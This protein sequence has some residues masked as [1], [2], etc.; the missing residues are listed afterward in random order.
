MKDGRTTL[1]LG[2]AL[3]ICVVLLTQAG[4]HAGAR[5]GGGLMGT[6][7]PLAPSTTSPLLGAYY[8]DW[9]PGNSSEGTLRQHLVPS[10][11]SDP[12]LVNSAEPSVASRAIAQASKAGISFFALDY[13][14]SRPAQN[15]NIRAFVRA[16]DLR[17]VHF[18]LLYETWDLG[19]DAAHEATPVTL[20]LERKFDRQLLQFARTYFTN[21]QYLRIQGRPVLV[22]YL[23]RTLTGDVGGMITQARRRL[24]QHG[25]DPYLIG[26]E[27]FWRVTRESPP[28]TGSDLTTSPQVARMEEFDAVTSYSL[29]GGGSDSALVPSHDFVGYPGTTSI[30]RDEVSLYRRYS[31]ATV[32]RVPVIPDVSPGVN[33]RGVRLSVN[34]PAEPRQWRAGES[35]GSTLT[36]LLRTVARPVLD[37]RLPMVF[38]TSWN[39]WN[40]DTGIQ[41]VGGTPTSRDDSPTGTAY[42]QGYTY[43]G[44]GSV[45]LSAIR[46]FEAVAWGRVT[47]VKGGPAAG[48]QVTASHN[49]RIVSRALT[50]AAGWYVMPRAKGTS[51]D[52]ILRAGGRSESI[53]SST[54]VARRSDFRV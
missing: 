28:A 13:W 17:D 21:P 52:L 5:N 22:L 47:G 41:P 24:R 12:T 1:A 20:P 42:T 26:D 50:N 23:T 7:G 54:S 36:Q 3:T 18:C 40:E 29:Y 10:Q 39:E 25:Y 2:T 15:K 37:P 8:S 4:A 27:V 43:G 33:T 45:D 51:G 48:L 19:Y 9:F 16:N 49:G 32:G 30:V 46:N 34:E 38:V 14:P 31:T 53:R 6:G 44:E 11:G 35:A